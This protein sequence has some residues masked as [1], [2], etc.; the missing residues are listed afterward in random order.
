LDI[1]D[2]ILIVFAF[3]AGGVLKG[4]VGAGAPLLAVPLMALTRDMQF[5]VAVFV[6]PNIV[7][8][9]IQAWA[10]RRQLSAP[11]FAATFAIAGGVGAGLGT[12]A[13]AGWKPDLLL[14]T[15][16]FVMVAYIL[17][18]AFNPGW[19]LRM[20]TGRLLAAPAG[21]LAGALQGATG[22]SA[23]VSL[24]FLGALR[25]EREDFMGTVSLFFVALGVVQ[26]P[27]Q[28]AFGIMTPERFLYS[29]LALIPLLLSMPLGSWIGARMPR[30]AFEWVI[31][32]ILFVL[33]VRL[34][35]GGLS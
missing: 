1:S 17:F 20:N 11:R 23:P 13:L 29:G 16:G 28:M 2:I 35:Y 3:A 7:P 26:L 31:L 10:Y 4:A 21:I 19:T 6:L 25:L 5:A 24:T 14:L 34:I 8:N 30:Q 27:A 12:I 9:V 15:V 22:L 33:A 18:R 32:F